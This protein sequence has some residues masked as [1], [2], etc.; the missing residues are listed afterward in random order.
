M[1]TEKYC[2]Q[3]MLQPISITVWLPCDWWTASSRE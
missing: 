1:Y 2:G 3:D